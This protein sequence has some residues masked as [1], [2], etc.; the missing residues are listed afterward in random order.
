MSLKDRLAR[1]LKNQPG[2]VASGDIQRIA[3]EKTSYTPSNVSRRLR[4][5]ENAN[6]VEVRYEKGH[7]YYR[8]RGQ[9]NVQ[10]LIR[11]GLDWFN[12]LPNEPASRA[13]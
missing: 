3:S 2:F 5:L 12:A 1:L 7:A 6:V 4:E 10:T 13:H 11:Q 9:P 8:Y